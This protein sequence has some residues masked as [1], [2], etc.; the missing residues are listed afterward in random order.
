MSDILGGIK[1][2]TWAPPFIFIDRIIHMSREN[3]VALTSF[4]GGQ[5]RFRYGSVTSPSLMVEAMA[6]LSLALI[7]YTDPEVKI[8][9]IPALRSVVMRPL[10]AHEFHATI[11]V[12]WSQGEFPRYGFEGTA[13]ALSEPVVEAGLDI[14]ARRGGEA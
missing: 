3:A 13:Y 7:R 6:Q 5:D 9:I 12:R 8:G 11:H 1:D 14:L 2:A 4:N 10:P